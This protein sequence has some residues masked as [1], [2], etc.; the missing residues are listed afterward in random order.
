MTI[1][2]FLLARIAE[3]EAVARRAGDVRVYRTDIGH[4]YLQSP[5]HGRINLPDVLRM[6]DGEATVYEHLA[7]NAPGR[8]LADCKAKRQAVT[9]LAALIADAER[10]P[11]YEGVTA[12]ANMAEELLEMLA[13]AHADHPDFREEWRA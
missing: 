1:T 9:F 13:S 7:F 5:Q 2:E 10:D 4:V 12:C 3:I 8:V 6:T 11:S